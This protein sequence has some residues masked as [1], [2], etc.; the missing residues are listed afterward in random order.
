V[1][2]VGAG[3]V[4]TA[5]AWLLQQRGHQVTL[6]DP[7]PVAPAEQDG[8]GSGRPGASQAALGVLMAQVF[9]RSS[10]RAW[11]LRQRSLLLWGEWRRQLEGRGHA[12]PW[13][14]GLL[15]L[16]ADA[17]ELERQ[18]RLVAER[19]RQGLPLAL[20]DRV[21]LEA[22]SPCLPAGALGGLYSPADG[23]LDPAAAIEA[24][25]SDA[26][27][28]GLIVRAG[29]AA[30]LEQ[31]G[32]VWRVVLEGGGTAEAEWVV[33][34]AGLACS[35][36]LSGLGQHW[37]LEPVLGQA[38][39]LELPSQAAAGHRPLP[40]W[41]WPGAVVWRGINLVPR[42]DLPGGD[43]FWL[44]ATMEPGARAD[45]AALARL[46]DLSGAA[47]D[48]LKGSRLVRQWQGLR[49]RPVGRPA[50]LLEAIA[51]GLL[52]AA[53]HHRNGV[54]LA[55]ASAEWVAMAIDQKKG[56]PSGPPA[57]SRSW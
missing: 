34:A 57:L 4:G 52:L 19:C 56:G 21:R 40:F 29:A 8:A 9:H 17:Q 25:R 48:W 47:P 5:C 55:P 28:A 15:L 22:Q 39:E 26:L 42:P 27:S 30:A 37:P 11:R 35:D 2:V 20:W 10:G 32:A 41:S 36:L 6:L 31:R 50:P 49:P 44:G 12:M 43:R 1:L 51:P 33:L 46:R 45:P 23:Q 16:A 3:I 13:R 24:L 54:L 14:A 7:A 38:M 18:E 53:G